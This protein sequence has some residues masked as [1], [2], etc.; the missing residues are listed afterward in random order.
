MSS[1]HIFS[2][3]AEKQEIFKRF[4]HPQSPSEVV[5]KLREYLNADKGDHYIFAISVLPDHFRLLYMKLKDEK[6]KGEKG[7]KAKR[8]VNSIRE[9]LDYLQSNRSKYD[10][11]GNFPVINTLSSRWSCADANCRE[12]FKIDHWVIPAPCGNCAW[13]PNCMGAAAEAAKI[14]MKS[15]R[16]FECSC[17]RDEE[18]T[19][20]R[21]AEDPEQE[22]PQ[23][24]QRSPEGDRDESGG[25]GEQ[26]VESGPPRKKQKSPGGGHVDSGDPGKQG[27]YGGYEE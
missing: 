26:G 12:S 8:L 7:E 11:E 5:R 16:Y 24:A 18:K 13:H 3:K 21:R 4:A 6:A 23:N 22:S 9:R 20:K 15:F 25:Q 14:S 19:R 10:P 17:T 1:V 2:N 27:F